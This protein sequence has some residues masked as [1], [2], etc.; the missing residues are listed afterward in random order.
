MQSIID[1]LPENWEAELE[2]QLLLRQRNTYSKSVYVCSPC[3]NGSKKAVYQNMRAA[4]FYM[5]HILHDM[6]MAA[7]APHAYLP[8]LL[9]DSSYSERSLALQ[10]GLRMLENNDFMFVCGNKISSGMRGEIER[11]AELGMPITVFH[12]DIYIEV[13]KIVTRANADKDL[14]GFEPNYPLLAYSADDLFSTEEMER[15]A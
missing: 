8:A 13:R 14:V 3:S 4:R 10:T 15:Y 7:R 6:C 9:S 1:R 11:A 12:H 2:F 5:R